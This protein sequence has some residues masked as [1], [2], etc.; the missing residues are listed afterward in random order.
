VSR[1]TVAA[2]FGAVLA[3]LVLLGS[4]VLLGAA[5][6][7][8][9]VGHAPGGYRWV[10]PPAGEAATAALPA[11][12]TTT[13]AGSGVALLATADRQA[14]AV[15]PADA[16]PEGTRV[17]VRPL[18]PATLGAPP[19]GRV[20][21]GNAYEVAAAPDGRRAVTSFQ[22]TLRYAR[23]GGGIAV[24]RDGRWEEIPA[25]DQHAAFQ[26]RL[27]EADLGTYDAVA[28]AATLA[29]AT[30]PG[31]AAAA[32]SSGRTVLRLVV[33]AAP[34]VLLLGLALAARRRRSA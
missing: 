33:L 23:L 24:L 21:D 25:V 2:P 13:T 4:Q 1:P 20:F 16:V 5:G 11:S 10:H 15:L 8:A 26:E 19:P 17:T 22:L 14:V 29:R 34:A 3:T 12:A 7:G 9:H 28:D 18:D 6:A 32:T 27:A 30:K 31:S